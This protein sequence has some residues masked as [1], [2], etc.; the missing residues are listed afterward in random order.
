MAKSF[1]PD[2]MEFQEYKDRL[3]R[4]AGRYKNVSISV[5]RNKRE[6]N[7]TT[8]LKYNDDVL[9][10]FY[11]WDDLYKIPRKYR[12]NVINSINSIVKQYILK[13]TAQ[14]DLRELHQYTLFE[15]GME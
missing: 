9:E 8:V 13:T 10:E 14:K 5:K 6:K 7:V 3:E 15:L 11:W 2:F 4:Y 1:N 12:K